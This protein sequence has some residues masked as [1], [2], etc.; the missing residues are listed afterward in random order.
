MKLS[1]GALL[2]ALA[3]AGAPARGMPPHARYLTFRPNSGRDP[4]GH[5]QMTRDLWTP[6]APSA[7]GNLA[8]RHDQR[9]PTGG[10]IA[11][12]V[13]ETGGAVIAERVP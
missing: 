6:Y 1:C 8:R 7:A 10:R 5:R 2:C 11:L 13:G 3:L 4:L 9:L 12:E